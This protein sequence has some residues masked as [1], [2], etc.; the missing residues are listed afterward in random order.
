MNLA[1]YS[2]KRYFAL[3]LL[4]TTL[5]W[6]QD[7]FSDEF[8]DEF[9]DAFAAEAGK[10]G[11]GTVLGF[12]F[13]GMVELEQGM[14]ITQTG[15]K[16]EGES[17]DDWVMANRRFRL[18]TQ[19]TTKKGGFFAKIDVV[20]DD[21][22]NDTYVDIREMRLQYTPLKWLD[23]SVGKQVSTWGVADML[24]IN[25]LFPKNWNANF[26][27]RDMEYL[28][29]SSTSLRLTSYLKKWTWDVVYT[30]EFAP[31]TTPTGC[32]LNVFDPNSGQ[33]ISNPDGCD[34]EN[35]AGGRKSRDVNDSELAMNLNRY[36]GA[37]Q[38][39]FYA[40][41]GFFKNPKSLQGSGTAE[42]PFRPF[43][44]RLNVF[45][46]STEGQFGPGIFTSEFGY[47][48]SKD[49]PNGD[50]PLVENS[51]VKYL[52]GY[53]MDVNANLTL[54]AQWYVE[55]YLDY[56][57]Y[58]ASVGFQPS[59]KREFAD[60][61]TLRV[62]YKAQQET[63]L[64]NLFTYVR[65]DDKDAFLKLDVSKRLDDNFSII[66]GVNVFDGKEGFESREFGMLKYDDNA[67]VRFKYVL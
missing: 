23:L 43:Y 39:S 66:A 37:H 65:P 24:F 5:A 10:E 51:K 44:S 22:S 27:G 61:F 3:G 13:T 41:R 47:Y 52:L 12:V 36:V 34:Y 2:F 42:D 60:T 35:M 67:F 63:L 29:D 9:E 49:D 53:K 62:M 57:A 46:A 32:Y 4:I 28:K 11:I 54:G 17:S 19:K 59:R 21:I 45:G 18:Q 15:P 50:N 40:Y 16:F 30:P 48:D 7:D 64:F 25:D 6:A 20:R 38:I 56:D 14:N 55:Q 33:I 58:E 8:S 26:L 31:D 1:A